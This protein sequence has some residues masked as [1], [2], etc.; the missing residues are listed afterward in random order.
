MLE[1]KSNGV[2]MWICDRLRGKPFK[3]QGHYYYRDKEGMTYEITKEDFEKL[4]GVDN[5]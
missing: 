1:I 2:T 4:G 3:K 5:D